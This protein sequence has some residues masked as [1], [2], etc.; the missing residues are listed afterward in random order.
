MRGL[1]WSARGLRLRAALLF[2][3]SILMLIAGLLPGL[4]GHGLAGFAA[5][6][7]V[8]VWMR[9]L[10]KP[11]LIA[12][13][14]HGGGA[15]A[16]AQDLAGQVL[17]ALVLFWLGT[18]LA[19]VWHWEASVNF[20]LPP[21]L[22]LV[23]GSLSRLIWRPMPPEWDGFLDEAVAGIQAAAAGLPPTPTPPP[24]RP[25]SA[26]LT[27]L[28]SALDALPQSGARHHDLV[29]AVT[30]ALG[31]M[32]PEDLRHALH[33]RIFDT[34]TERDL[35]ALV[36]AHTDPF[37]ARQFLGQHDLEEIF[38]LIIE[39]GDTAALS[40]FAG[41][42]EAVLDS[43]P[44]ACHDLPTPHRLRSAGLTTLAAHVQRLREEHPEA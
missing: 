4:A 19:L 8:Y 6:A 39:A 21:A 36:V 13:L 37:V 25:H 40:A 24:G 5:V 38:D 22:A 7:A 20:W 26:A 15:R 9:L 32:S 29:A 1:W 14:R 42:V 11:W 28:H 43:V 35:R 34:T 41:A 12:G 17:V 10:A 18:L 2:A 44:E 3:L 33:E 27:A 30:A 23:G 31:D 16:L